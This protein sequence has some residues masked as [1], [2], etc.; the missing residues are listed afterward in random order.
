MLVYSGL[1]AMGTCVQDLGLCYCSL[2][3]LGLDDCLVL[4]T[5]LLL[6]LWVW[7]ARVSARRLQLCCNI[8]HVAAFEYLCICPRS[9][10]HGTRSRTRPSGA[11]LLLLLGW[12]TR[13]QAPF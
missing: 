6:C 9:G 8:I 12:R 2:L 5:L 1:I 3:G 11:Q 10:T 13:L 4:A 7:V